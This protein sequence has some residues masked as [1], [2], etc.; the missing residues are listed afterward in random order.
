MKISVIILAAGQGSRMHSTLPK[1][2]HTIGG[3][4][5]L[6]YVIRAALEAIT[7]QSE[8][9][10]VSSSVNVVTGY[11]AEQVQK[12]F[13]HYDV[14]WVIQN[15]LL[16]TGHAVKQALPLCADADVILVLYGDVP[17]INSQTLQRLMKISAGEHLALLTTELDNATGYGRIIRN[18]NN[19]ITAITEERDATEAQRQIGEINTGLMA[20]PGKYSQKW[21]NTLNN[22]NQQQEYY[23]TDIVAQAVADNIQVVSI[24]PENQTEVQGVNSRQQQAKLE[25]EFQ[26]MQAEHLMQRGVTLLDYKRID[27]RGNL[28]TGRDITIDINCIF[29]GDVILGNNVSVGAGSVICNTHIDDGTIIEPYSVITDSKIGKNCRIGP[30]ARIRPGTEAANFVKIGNFVETKK[31]NIG[32]KTK[33]GHLSYVGDAN[34]GTEVNIGAGTITCNYD[35]ANKHETT[36][37][38]H[39]FIGSNT[40]LI[41]PVKV[42]AYAST[43]AGSAITDNV[44][45][46]QL[47]VARSRQQNIT[48]W[49][50]PEKKE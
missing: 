3:R 38:D 7:A 26:R 4:P 41:A 48:G 5:M 28:V 9:T 22:E 12:A 40:A 25:R 31:A 8:L 17:L 29:S 45:N 15:E 2:L 20:I 10:T 39:V 33:I 32:E 36:I 21:I 50:R 47:A 23:L 14:N 16:G 49:S 13:N 42:G 46:K 6:E 18:K 11:G 27:I 1:V 34:I 24:H 44:E 43:G 37:E 30:F 19:E 35:G